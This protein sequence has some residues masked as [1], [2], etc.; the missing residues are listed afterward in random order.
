MDGL[1]TSLFKTLN[2]HPGTFPKQFKAENCTATGR[3]WDDCVYDGVNMEMIQYS[4]IASA[5]IFNFVLGFTSPLV[6]FMTPFAIILLYLVP[7][8]AD[9]PANL[10][11]IDY[12]IPFYYYNNEFDIL[13]T[14]INPFKWLPTM[15]EMSMD[16][17]HT[18][19]YLFVYW[20]QYF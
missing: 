2:F 5:A 11:E 14:M 8:L 3:S 15:L 1:R 6:W 20:T 17:L 19:S 9:T 18:L 12:G 10:S 4:N 7:S 13:G 16:Y